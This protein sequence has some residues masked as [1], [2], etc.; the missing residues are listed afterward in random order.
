VDKVA[1]QSGFPRLRLWPALPVLIILG[2]A[3]HL[4]VPQISSLERSWSIMKGMTWWALALAIVSQI[5]SYLG[6]GFMLRAIVN[7]DR[8]KLSISKGAM[9]ALA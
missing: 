6:Y 4:L 8:K 1:N 5:L 2:L 7:L 3:V 9:I